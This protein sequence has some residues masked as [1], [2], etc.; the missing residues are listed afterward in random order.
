MFVFRRSVLAVLLALLFGWAAGPLQAQDEAS[1]PPGVMA[2]LDQDVGLTPEQVI[3]LEQVGAAHISPDG[4]EVA[5]TLVRPTD[6]RE[7]ND[8][9]A[10]ELHVWNAETGRSTPFV[11]GDVRVQDVQWTPSGD[12]LTFLAQREDDAHA[13]LY[14][15]PRDG[16]EARA[17]YRFETAI[18]GYDW[19]PDGSRIVFTAPEPREDPDDS[20]PYEPRVYRDDPH[21]TRAY[22]VTLDEPDSDPRRVR[23]EGTVRR[24]RWSPDGDR[25]AISRTPT[26]F[27][28][29]FYMEQRIRIVSAEDLEV[30]ASIDNPGK[31]GELAWSPDGERIAFVAG[32]DEHDTIDGRL[33]VADASTDGFRQIL[34]GYEGK[35]DDLAWTG[36]ETV[37]FS[38]S[39]GVWTVLSEVRY[40]GSDHEV[41]VDTG[42]PIINEFSSTDRGTR[43]AVV[44][45][46]PEHPRELYLLDESS[47]TP[48]RATT[49]NPGLDEVELGAQE[50]V[51]YEARDGLEIEGVLVRPVEGTSQA[52]HSTIMI[53]HGGPESHYDM[54][55]LTDYA[56]LGQ[57]AAAHGFAVFYP[58]YRGSTGRGREF[59]TT[60]QGDPAGREFEDLVD[61]VDYLI[62][63][64]ITDPE[65]V[66]VTG[67][68]Y[69][70][71][72]T[73]WMATRY[74][75]RFAAGVMFVGISDLISSWGSS[76]IPREL[77]QVHNLEHVWEDWEFYLERSPIYHT[78]DAGT[79]LLIMEG[80]EDTRVYP[81]Q[82]LEMYNFLRFRSDAPVRLVTYPGEGHGNRRAM[83][84]YDYML[85]S[86]RWMEHYLRGPGGAK[87]DP[88]LGR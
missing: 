37:R 82:S 31:L 21:H 46:S 69:G 24:V 77:Y 36:P 12:A 41:L 85:R 34:T 75:E 84:E 88:S 67:G 43:T 55:W 1:P 16:G 60:S 57:V 44:A 42:G 27:I 72:A 61:G 76:D 83:A 52:P 22:V 58:N 54:G 80:A 64:G 45:D 5:Y 6:P 81:S 86:L 18:D 9:P 35:I 7:T 39:R 17:I 65:S 68:S 48:E 26:P 15:I 29:D 8:L 30:A 63:E 71:Y 62:D 53:V 50:V 73:G 14:R 51:T 40:D 10:V 11:S 25:I 13:V 49:H 33:M 70:G 20:L 2:L 3:Q 23:V 38:A 47:S 19:A 78:D 4:R 59:A 66:G 28:D 87:P 79:P 74:T 32:A 56:D